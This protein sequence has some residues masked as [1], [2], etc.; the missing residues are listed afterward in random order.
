MARSR[1]KD[2]GAL[3][4]KDDGAL[5]GKGD[6]PQPPMA[7]RMPSPRASD[8]KIAVG[9]I[10]NRIATTR[11]VNESWIA[12]SAAGEPADWSRCDATMT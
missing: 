7:E 6:G 2:N 3:A 12:G 11:Q 8:R 1:G 4:G 10:D 5:A 9:N